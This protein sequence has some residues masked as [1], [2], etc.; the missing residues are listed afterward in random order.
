MS[1]ITSSPTAAATA[2]AAALDLL[3]AQLG[4]NAGDLED[5]LAKS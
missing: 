2:R 4:T 1:F 5:R 3:A